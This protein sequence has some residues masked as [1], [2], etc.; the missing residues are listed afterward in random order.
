MNEID[1]SLTDRHMLIKQHE[2]ASEDCYEGKE[3]KAM[4]ECQCLSL[5]ATRSWAQECT[6]Y[7]AGF[8]HSAANYELCDLGQVYLNEHTLTFQSRIIT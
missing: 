6:G 2:C 7:R 5:F 8:N 1:M 3:L 4:R